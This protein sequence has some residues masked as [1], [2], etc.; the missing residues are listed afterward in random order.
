[1]ARLP[2]EL[3][4]LIIESIRGATNAPVVFSPIRLAC[5][6]FNSIV[7]PFQ[8][9][10]IRLLSSP[11]PASPYVKRINNFLELLNV[12]P[13]I[14]HYVEEVRIVW[15]LGRHEADFSLPT[16]EFGQLCARLQ[17]GKRL[18]TLALSRPYGASPIHARYLLESVMLIAPKIEKLRLVMVHNIPSY[19]F[20]S[21]TRLETVSL[22]E[23]TYTDLANV[24]PDFRPSLKEF[25]Y[26]STATGGP[27]QPILELFDFSRLASFA[28]LTMYFD[29]VE[30]VLHHIRSGYQSMISTLSIDITN[31]P[32]SLLSQSP[33]RFPVL[34]KLTLHTNEFNPFRNYPFPRAAALLQVLEVPRLSFVDIQAELVRFMD[35]E[36]YGMPWDV[37]DMELVRIAGSNGSLSVAVNFPHPHV[38]SSRIHHYANVSPAKLLKLCAA[39]PFVSIVEH[40]P[41][42]YFP[43]IT[44]SSF[45]RCGTESHGSRTS[46]PHQPSS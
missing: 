30:T 22:R 34:Q 28:S 21:F 29:T 38:K 6:A 41:L 9:N 1:M 20:K 2:L 24:T 40:I 43:G 16:R 37:V 10:V 19:F 26:I 14:L 42:R 27:I 39:S 4:S 31:I 18:R 17:A 11:P 35:Y 33:F 46:F 13:S 25:E 7:L 44:K 5:H 45:R 12:N 23:V 32:A 36:I 15:V 3:L 8:F